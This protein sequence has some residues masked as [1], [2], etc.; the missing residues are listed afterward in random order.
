[1]MVQQNQRTAASSSSYNMNSTSNSNNNYNTRYDDDDDSQ[2]DDTRT[3]QQGSRGQ[4]G[5]YDKGE[6]AAATAAEENENESV[7]CLIA[8]VDNVRKVSNMLKAIHIRDKATV[9]LTTKQHAL[10]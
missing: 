2:S 8:Q 5:Q 7:P 3:I 1:M 10:G 9:F 6:D 4:Q